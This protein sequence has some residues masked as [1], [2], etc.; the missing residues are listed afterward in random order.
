MKRLQQKFK[1]AAL[2]LEEIDLGLRSYIYLFLAILAFRLCL[3]FFANQK[4]F[5]I[6]DVIHIGLWFTFILLAF[7]VQLHLF[8]R[9]DLTRILKL[10]IV[11]FSI[12]LT[13]PIIDLIISQGKLV[14]MNYLSIHSF[15]DFLFSYFTIGGA[16]LTRGATIGIRV[17]IILLMLA[18]FN[19][20]Y[21]KRSSLLIAFLGSFS[22]YTILFLS[23]TV[24]LI[25]NYLTQAV[26]LPYAL[27]DH[28]TELLLFCIDLLLILYIS[29]KIA[30]KK[31][32]QP[33]NLPTIIDFVF[34]IGA[35]LYGAS[36]ARMRYPENWSLNA[37]SV[38]HF[39]ILALILLL[40]FR[41]LNH[42]NSSLDTDK[43][44]EHYE[45]G[46]WL[47]VL[48]SGLIIS[49]YSFFALLLIWATLFV[50]YEKPTVWIKSPALSVFFKSIL[51]TFFVFFGFLT[52]GA[53]L[54]GIDLL[55]LVILL[56]IVLVI[57]ILSSIFIE[58]LSK[59]PHNEKFQD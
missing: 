35:L 37:S 59:T 3:E 55:H 39:P 50:L 45:N 42:K 38:F 47:L 25:I 12:A 7:I 52:F 24:P 6:H 30:G 53:P 41:Y 8:S 34:C 17:E 27:E 46:F 22:I 20:I 36:L 40:F 5:S 2:F 57:R 21:V 44:N 31:T 14:K 11:C 23:G 19:Y 32:A 51:Y 4:L 58:K 43:R 33:L 54:I 56:L 18:S 9:V 10:C 28:S 26:H 49:F 29:N 48:T 16:S 13:A 1:Q 15:Q